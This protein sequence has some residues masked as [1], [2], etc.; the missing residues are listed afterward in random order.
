MKTITLA[1][2]EKDL[3]ANVD[4]ILVD[5]RDTDSYKRAHL[6]KAKCI[7]PECGDDCILRAFP[8]KNKKIVTYC[9]SVD[10]SLSKQLCVVLERLGY[11]NTWHY[12][13][14]IKEW[15]ARK[16]PVEDKAGHIIRPSKE[17]RIT[18]AVR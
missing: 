15:I 13:G 12:A 18:Q 4:F 1:Q 9:S 3:A 17:D 2:L 6:P 5:A 14:G 10:C 11:T 16:N 7:S 8:E